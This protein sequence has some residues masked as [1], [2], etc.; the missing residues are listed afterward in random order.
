MDLNVLNL[1]YFL[2]LQK[3]ALTLFSFNR[4]IMNMILPTKIC[5]NFHTQIFNTFQK[6]LFASM[7]ALKKWEKMLFISP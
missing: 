1:I 6:V 3:R 5:I 2:I 4:K 7:I